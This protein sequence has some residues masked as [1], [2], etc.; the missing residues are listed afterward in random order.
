VRGRYNTTTS[1]NQKRENGVVLHTPLALSRECQ[2]ILTATPFF[3]FKI[4][5]LKIKII[6]QK[7]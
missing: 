6:R 1:L 2:K 3:F 7:K 5:T 4:K